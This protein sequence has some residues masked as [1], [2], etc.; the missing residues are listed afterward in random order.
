MLQ[1]TRGVVLQSVNFSETSIVV[2]IYTEDF[3][4]QSF[5]VKSV[6]SPKAKLKIALFQPL[7]LLDLVIYHN[8]RATLH[9]IREARTFYTY[10]SLSVDFQKSTIFVFLSEILSKCLRTEQPDKNLFHFL[11]NSLQL[12]DLK[13]TYYTDFHLIFLMQLSR[14]LGFYP[15]GN[16]DADLRWF[17][18]AEGT[19]QVQEP[20][21]SYSMN[22]E[23]SKGLSKL[24]GIS[25][26]DENL[27]LFST[28]ERRVMLEQIL[29]FYAL[30]VPG[31]GNIQSHKILQEVL[32]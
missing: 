28:P 11:Y 21:H 25:L 24:K 5:M 4:L 13:Q 19:F 15:K 1:K 29:Q 2:K 27:C 17:D 8:E 26:S 23:N 16:Y 9:S 30:H 6:R 3:G 31:F 14:F 12:L 32:E 10:T 18:M 22:A 20:V 7:T